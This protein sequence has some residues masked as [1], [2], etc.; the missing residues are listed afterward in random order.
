MSIIPSVAKEKSKEK[1]GK[2]KITAVTNAQMLN[3]KESLNQEVRIRNEEETISFWE[4]KKPQGKISLANHSELVFCGQAFP[5]LCPCPSSSALNRHFNS[6]AHFP[7]MIKIDLND[8]I[9]SVKTNSEHKIQRTSR[10]DQTRKKE[11]PIK[12][13][14]DAKGDIKPEP[15]KQPLEPQTK[16]PEPEEATAAV[17]EAPIQTPENDNDN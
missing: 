11:P 4:T 15:V 6:S 17:A 13:P 8:S 7:K 10:N 3:I 12:P 9:S 1:T 2:D 14:K 16:S 5:S